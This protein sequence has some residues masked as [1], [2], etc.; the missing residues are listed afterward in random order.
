MDHLAP[1]W[2]ARAP[3]PALNPRDNTY[4]NGRSFFEVHFGFSKA[5]DPLIEWTYAPLK[6]I[7]A[8]LDPGASGPD[9]KIRFGRSGNSMALGSDAF[10]AGR[11]L[12]D[13]SA[14]RELGFAGDAGNQF[15]WSG[16]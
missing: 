16:P 13:L 10:L 8:S 6:E 5:P 12:W 3:L 9:T 1:L 4:Q 11:H 7:R 2:D 14:Q 15:S